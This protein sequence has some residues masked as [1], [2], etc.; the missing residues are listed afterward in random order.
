MRWDPTAGKH[1][2]SQEWVLDTDGNNMFDVMM[3]DEIDRT[4][5]KSNDVV[6]IL[7]VSPRVRKRAVDSFSSVS[8]V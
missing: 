5:I 7:Q 2:A 8:N 1:A 3:L 6:E 4:R